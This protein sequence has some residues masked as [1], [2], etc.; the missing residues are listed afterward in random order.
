MLWQKSKTKKIPPEIVD[1]RRYLKRRN[2]SQ[3]TIVNYLTHI[4]DFF[5]F[6]KKPVA[7][8]GRKDIGNYID[9]LQ[10][11]NYKPKTINCHLGSIRQ[12][13]EY[14]IAENRYPLD[15]PVPKHYYLRLPDPLPRHLKEEEVNQLLAVVK[16]TRDQAI[17]LLMVRCGLRVSEVANLKIKHLDLQNLRCEI[18]ESKWGKSRVVYLAQDAALAI[19]TYLHERYR[20]KSE[21]LFVSQKGPSKGKPLGMRAIQKRIE[22][23]TN[24]VGLDIS[25]HHLRHTMA[26]NLLDVDAS[27]EAIQGLLGHRW[28]STTQRYCRVS[29]KKV[30]QEYFTAMSKV[31]Q[32]TV[33]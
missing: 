15:N 21:Y 24:Q 16:K 17:L 20:Y 13:Y 14:L 11:K 8:I 6:V 9:A 28:I 12:L 27:L 1:F 22:Y 18:H 33:P 5:D 23:Y 2:Y 26:T 3:Y 19:Q 32:S 7:Q 25:C 10:Q 31:L 30:E 29:D 4:Y